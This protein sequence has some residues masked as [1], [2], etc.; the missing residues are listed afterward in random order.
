[1]S[2][3]RCSTRGRRERCGAADARTFD[4]GVNG[5]GSDVFQSFDITAGPANFDGFHF[6]DG[7][8]T[9]VKTQIVLR[10]ITSSA[11]DFAELLYACSTNGYSCADC[12]AVALCADE[13]EEDA[14]IAIGVPI[15]Q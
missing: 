10:E 2:T 4:E 15:F 11:T 9:E 8:E 14:M 5:V 6:F 12:G 3:V 13:L 1:M 7:A